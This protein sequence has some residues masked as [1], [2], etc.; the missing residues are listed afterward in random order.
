MGK[1]LRTI[2]ALAAASFSVM[3]VNAQD[4]AKPQIQN[5]DFESWAESTSSNH[6]PDNWNS[7]ETAGGKLAG[8]VKAQQVKS[9]NEVRPGSA[10]KTS[11]VIWTRS[12]FGIPAQG[13]LTLGQIQAGSTNAADK[14]NHNKSIT[15]DE[16]YSQKLG[17]L[18]DSIVAWVKYVPAAELADYPYA[19]MSATVHDSYDYIEY[20]SSSVTDET[21][22]SHAVAHAALNFKP[23]KDADGKC[24]WQRISVPF[25]TEG[26][27]ATSPDYIIVNFT[28]NSTPGKGTAGDSLYIDDVELVYAETADY[29]ELAKD[30]YNGPLTVTLNGNDCP[31]SR[32]N[33]YLKR[34]DKNL[35][36]LSL[37]NFKLANGVNEA[38][39]EMEYMYVGNIVVDSIELTSEDG[40]VADFS[41]KATILIAEGT[42]PSDV[43]WLG[44]LLQEVNV[45]ANGNVSPDALKVSINISYS[46]MD[47]K[48][49]VEGE[50][51]E[52]DS[53]R[54][55]EADSDSAYAVYSVNG[56]KV[57]SG[58]GKP[59]TDT[60]TPGVYVIKQGNKTVKQV[61]K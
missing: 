14:T 48:V 1:S 17:V 53:I 61:I 27:T 54:G 9:S 47:I 44:P 30:V 46:N 20:G 5:G 51:G 37:N 23:S 50:P 12:V 10:G 13:N 15:S 4:E 57:A 38:T 8:F 21:N 7:F 35:V 24:Q 56:V 55:V 45:D 26:C 11:A 6:A 58:T 25:S 39:G 22:E 49:N 31:S 28:T 59:A 32:E 42:D 18:P 29:T 40:K 41:K 3:G 60:L 19:R 43:M 36:Q 52:Y 33:I 2:L 16:K 34:I